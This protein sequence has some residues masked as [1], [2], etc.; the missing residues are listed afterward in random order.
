MEL[1]KQA[2]PHI[3]TVHEH[4]T[5]ERLD[6][7]LS[8]QMP[9]YSRSFFKRLIEAGQVT[10]N[11]KVVNRQSIVIKKDDV[12]TVDCTVKTPAHHATQLPPIS[13]VLEHP[14][15]WIIN[16][17]ANLV[18]HR[19]PTATREPS[20][21]DWLLQKSNDIA[22]VGDNERPGIVHRLDKDTSGL[23]I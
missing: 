6:L 15:F 11:A 12:V 7:F 16:K 19:A 21:V 17:P 23:L 18:V 2:S 14:H 13:I 9:H 1:K 22:Q 4:D 10:L 3:L 20:V 5:H 8:K